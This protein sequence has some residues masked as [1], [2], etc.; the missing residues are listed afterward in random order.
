MPG[1]HKRV[2][3]WWV[4]EAPG[5]DKDQM[6]Y[7]LTHSAVER[8]KE[9]LDLLVV[10][11]SDLEFIGSSSDANRL[12]ESIAAA[13]HLRIHPYCDLNVRIDFKNAGPGKFI[14]RHKNK[15]AP[16]GVSQVIDG[17]KPEIV[18][19]E[20][21]MSISEFMTEGPY[22]RMINSTPAIWAF[23][24]WVGNPGTVKMNLSALCSKHG[25]KLLE[26]GPG[27]YDI[28]TFGHGKRWDE[29]LGRVV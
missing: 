13:K 4:S 1:Y 2:K 9:T 20:T 14:V 10:M 29:E 3:L 8:M 19:G 12:K 26:H 27:I 24:Q 28:E 18:G 22:K 7:N 25:W 6:G 11:E 21:P 16:L 17:K 15:M 5:K 23:N